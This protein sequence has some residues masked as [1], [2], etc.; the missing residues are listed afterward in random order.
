MSSDMF[1]SCYPFWAEYCEQVLNFIHR[2]PESDAIWGQI[3]AVPHPGPRNLLPCCIIVWN[4]YV[5]LLESVPRPPSAPRPIKLNKIN[6]WFWSAVWVHAHWNVL[7]FVW[8]NV[9]RKSNKSKVENLVKNLK[10]EQIK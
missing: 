1:V 4:I 7:M 6:Q 3:Y 5:Q 10:M 2:Q 8:L 9:W